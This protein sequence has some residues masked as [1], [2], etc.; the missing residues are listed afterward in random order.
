MISSRRKF[1]FVLAG[2]LVM[3]GQ[4]ARSAES[5]NILFLFAD[6]HA[7]DAIRA[8][9][10][11]EI[12]TPNLDRLAR[13]GVTFSHAYNMGAW[14]GAVCVASRTMLNTGLFL[15]RAQAAEPD[16]KERFVARRQTWP[17]LLE[18]AGYA[19]Y[20]TGKWHVKAKPEEIFQTATHVRGGMPEQTPEGYNRPL[21]PDDH[22]WKP[23][24]TK[25]GGF[26]EGGKH[27]SE[28]VADDAEQFFAEAAQSDRPFFMY[29]AFNAPHDPRQSPKEFVDRYPLER[30]RLPQPFFV[31][32]PFEIGSNRCRDEKLAP[33]PRTE[34]AVK[35][36]RQE[37]YAII[38]H[39]DEQ[40]G[41]ILAAL[42]ASG[43]ADN[44]YIFFTADHGLAVG[45]HGLMGKQN[46]YDHS[47][48][49][50]FFVVGPDIPHGQQLNTPIY[51]QD[52][53]PSTL[54]LAGVTPPKH[55]E[56]QSMLPLIRGERQRSYDRIYGAYMETQ[57][58][59]TDGDYKLI[60]Y[61]QVPKRLLYHLA[62]DPLEENDL[63]GD[64]RHAA[65]MAAMT[66]KL[67]ELQGQMDDKLELKNEAL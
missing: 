56:F 28:V 27:W 2:V 10:N 13:Q 50:P 3:C 42:Q 17:Q 19:T 66:K 4:W 64:P 51:L 23:W 54:E 22:T 61:P 8:T 31:D 6:D 26:W 53:M 44:T 33:F 25:F 55:V 24:D 37:Y 1:T 41:R 34:F 65:R 57:R 5:P 47:V 14:H 62:E 7:F 21:G 59:I 46:M 20:F 52:V 43:K 49:V 58:M 45:H 38:T 67:R 12:E 11:D 29:V 30:I 60:I 40:V 39:M 63:S 36:N 9:G 35:V 15:W 16:L 18:Q 32:Y 48:R